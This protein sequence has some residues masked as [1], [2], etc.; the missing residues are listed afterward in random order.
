MEVLMRTRL[1][2]SLAKPEDVFRLPRATIASD[3]MALPFQ[4]RKR[5]SPKPAVIPDYTN[6]LDLFSQ[7]PIDTQAPVASASARPSGEHYARPR[8][9]QQLDFDALEPLPPEDAGAVAAGQPAPADTGGDGGAV[10]RP[11]VRAG[12]GA[13]D[14]T[15]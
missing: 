2:S 14:G 13:E 9:P 3:I 6:Q 7:A 11:P 4:V 12:V 1:S 10:R 15:P 8:P 5:W